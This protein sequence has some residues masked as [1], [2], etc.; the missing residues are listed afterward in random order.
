MLLDR[1]VAWA[2]RRGKPFDAR[3]EPT[4]GHVR[5]AAGRLEFEV[6]QRARAEEIEQWATAVERAAYGGA[7][8]DARAQAK[9]DDLAPPDA[10]KPGAGVPEPRMP[11]RAR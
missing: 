7:P 9:V 8:V 10:S 11:P 5:R 4:P 2:R 1:L 3:P 6:D